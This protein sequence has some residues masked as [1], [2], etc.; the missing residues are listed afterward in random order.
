M[1][2]VR[3]LDILHF[4][5]GASLKTRIGLGWLGDLS[6]DGLRA[7]M[8]CSVNTIRARMDVTTAFRS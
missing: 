4:V 5:V 2:R 6:L 3:V 1:N 8:V 7:C